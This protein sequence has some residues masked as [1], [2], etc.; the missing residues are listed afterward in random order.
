VTDAN[1][2]QSDTSLF[3]PFLFDG[4]EESEGPSMIIMPNP[5][6]NL[7]LIRLDGVWTGEWK[8]Q[9]LDQS[10]K[11]LLESGYNLKPEAS[12]DVSELPAGM[13]FVRISRSDF[14][15]IQKLV[16]QR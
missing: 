3:Y 5:A 12:V 6:N 10:G 2:C 14:S 15:R 1:G 7:L 13:Y 9:L 4:V 8:W 16:I 11:L